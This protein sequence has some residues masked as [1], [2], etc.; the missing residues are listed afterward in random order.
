MF[1][2][3]FTRLGE[4]GVSFAISQRYSKEQ[5]KHYERLVAIE[6]CRDGV[7]MLEILPKFEVPV[8]SVR[9][10]DEAGVAV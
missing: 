4:E 2:I 1:I 9:V 5:A 3:E 8:E 7:A 6:I 10:V